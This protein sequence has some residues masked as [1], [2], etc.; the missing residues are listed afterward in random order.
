MKQEVITQ[1]PLFGKANL[2][3][4]E[5]GVG[6]KKGNSTSYPALSSKFIEVPAQINL[7]TEINVFSNG[8]EFDGWHCSN[9]DNCSKFKQDLSNPNELKQGGCPL[10][11]RL[12]I[13]Y[14]DNGKIPFKTAK[15]IGYKRLSIQKNGI[16]VKLSKCNELS[17]K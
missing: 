15:R 13:A 7:L 4:N 1:Y 17:Q 2:V 11:L 12:A 3:Q 16:F 9:C 8:S 14:M 6:Y 5:F 10:E